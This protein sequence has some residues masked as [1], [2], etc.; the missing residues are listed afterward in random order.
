[1]LVRHFGRAFMGNITPNRRKSR[2]EIDMQISCQFHLIYNQKKGRSIMQ[3]V[4]LSGATGQIGSYMAEHL[5]TKGYK[6]FGIKRR[7]SSLNT[8]RIDHIFDNPNLK[9]EYGDLTDYSSIAN[10]VSLIKPDL[11]INCGAQS[12]VRVSFDVPL[13]TF[14]STGASVINCLEAIKNHSPTTRF[15]TMSSSEMFGSSPP[16]QNENTIFHPRSVYAI[17]KL[18]GYH[19][20]VHY[21][22]MGLFCSNAICFNTES[23]RRGETFVT[24]KITRIAARI[25]YGL[26][27][28]L[29]LGNIKS[30]RDWI[31]AKD[32]VNA[33]Y[34]IITADKPNDYVIA[35]GQMR[36][37]EEFANIVFSKLGLNAQDYIEFDPHY[38]RPTEVDQLCGDSSKLR[39]ELGWLPQYSFDDLV[40]EMIASD[41]KLAEQEILFKDI[42]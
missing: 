16:P 28:K 29:Y 42:P 17:A 13:F 40:N 18:A 10:L 5:L 36:T 35:T 12:H 32:S 39:R 15:I 7:S 23:P 21:R 1:V 33:I 2:C 22:E 11:F 9:L 25:K 37:V 27:D 20:V 4:I 3:S 24:R 30:A 8:Q 34:Q 38:L 14:Q 31:H 41:L 6:V 19:A 26:Q